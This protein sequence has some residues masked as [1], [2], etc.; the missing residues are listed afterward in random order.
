MLSTIVWMGGGWGLL[1]KPNLSS[2]HQLRAF[3]SFASA[4]QKFQRMTLSIFL[5]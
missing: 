4:S 5:L 2:V 3:P 1:L